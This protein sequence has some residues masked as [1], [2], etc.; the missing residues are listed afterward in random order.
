MLV[1]IGNI[2]GS[3]LSGVLGGRYSKRY[4]LSSLYFARAAV[5]FV[6]IMT[7]VTPASVVIFSFS[8]GLLWLST[9]P[10]TSGLVAQ[11]FGPRYMATLFGIVFFSHQI[12]S[13]LGAWLGGY[14]YDLTGSYDVVWWLSVAL[15]VFSGLVH[16]PIDERPVARLAVA[17]AR[18]E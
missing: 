16:W 6:F 12:G 5:F 17:R 13:F 18:V 1:G 14:F 10:L 2:I 15:G 3:W 8:L 7:P 4:L 9:V 11:I